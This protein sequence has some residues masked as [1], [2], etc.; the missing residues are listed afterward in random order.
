ME[1]LIV[2][3]DVHGDVDR[4]N[5]ILAQL[6]PYGRR[7][8]FVGDYVDG[9]PH[10]AKVLETLIGLAQRA[11]HRFTFLCGN[12]DLALLRYVEDGN[13]ARYTRTGGLATLASYLPAVT[14]DVHAAFL[15]VFPPAHRAFLS[16]L[17]PYWESDG[18]LVTHTGF[19]PARPEARDAE[20]LACDDG[21]PIFRATNFPRELV[22]CGHYV[23][24]QEPFVSDQLICLDTGC[25]LLRE[26][27]LT[28]VLLPEREFLTA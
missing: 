8:V 10:S 19:N 6:E 3:G 7:V 22:V 12:H 5:R 15:D 27:R 20:T 11:P 4:L 16:A 1:P 17:E 21:W 28:A 25:G 2:V 18:C 14:G 9:G 24:R 26:G 13:F 23:Q